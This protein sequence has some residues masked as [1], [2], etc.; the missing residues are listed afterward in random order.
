MWAAIALSFALAADAAA[1]SAARALARAKRSEM[2]ILP[3]VFGG[4]Q[5]GMATLGWLG[6]DVIE[7]RYAGW[8]RWIACGLLVGVGVKMVLDARRNA[9]PTNA[10]SAMVY[11]GL[12]LATSIDAAASGTSLPLLSVAPWLALSLIGSITAACSATAFAIGR[13][14]GSRFGNRLTA[15]AGVLL[16]FIGV[17]LWLQG[18]A[19]QH[20]PNAH[21]DHANKLETRERLASAP[22]TRLPKRSGRPPTRTRTPL[23]AAAYERLQGLTFP[24]FDARPRGVDAASGFEVRQIT[25][26]HPRIWATI[27]ISPCQPR[28][29]LGDCTAM[30]L[31][32]WRARTPQLKQALLHP[33]LIDA[34]DTVFEVATT[35]IN[36]A[37]WIYQYQL[38]QT[39]PA[40]AS[41]GS[42]TAQSARRQGEFAWSHAYVLYY[43]DG[44][45]QIRVVAEY[46]DDPASSKEEMAQRVPREDLEDVAKAFADAYTQAWN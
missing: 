7:S 1:V 19:K 24:G 40:R 27:T 36:G 28:A 35:A 3:L 22:E 11:V 43:N 5:A 42:S 34:P 9:E 13:G 16:I 17:D 41:D 15:L 38:A 10:A 25:E 14:L 12:G 37:Q 45:N 29:L 39:A 31:E 6:G 46:K 26:G 23:E 20:R 21:R 33:D 44:T 30:S 18:P 4:F 32:A 8:G 2:V